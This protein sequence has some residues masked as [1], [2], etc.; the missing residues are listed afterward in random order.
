M[1]TSS[2]CTA[3]VT[4]SGDDLRRTESPQQEPPAPFESHHC[5]LYLRLLFCP[6]PSTIASSPSLQSDAVRL[7]LISRAPPP[8]RPQI[9]ASLTVSTVHQNVPNISH[10]NLRT[11][12]M[13]KLSRSSA[14]TN[15][16]R[17][18]NHFK[19]CAGTRLQKLQLFVLQSATVK[20]FS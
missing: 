10:S 17:R 4:F 5:R 12:S 14:E 13:L 9:P 16:N 7:Q 6:K 2:F 8:S 19:N 1:K 18:C 15:Q 11:S 20:I 3:T